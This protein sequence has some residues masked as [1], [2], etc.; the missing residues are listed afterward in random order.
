MPEFRVGMFLLGCLGGLVPDALRIIKNRKQPDTLYCF[1]HFT[2]WLALVL[3]VLLGGFVVY[4]LNTASITKALS[5]GFAA[6]EI[7]GGLISKKDEAILRAA[8]AAKGA[9]EAEKKFKL[10]S[11]LAG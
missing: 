5:V 6:P 4:L 9:G 8:A 11:W 10:R 7:I 3:Q 1:K 2:Y